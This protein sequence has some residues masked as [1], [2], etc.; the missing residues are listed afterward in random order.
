MG[1]RVSDVARIDA[2]DRLEAVLGKHLRDVDALGEGELLVGVADAVAPRQRE[3]LDQQ[4]ALGVRD[5]RLGNRDRRP[6]VEPAPPVRD[7]LPARGVVV[8]RVD[9][10]HRAAAPGR[11]QRPPRRD[12]RAPG[13]EAH[14]S[15][16]GHVDADVADERPPERERLL[17]V[18]AAA[19]IAVA[20]LEDRQV[21]AGERRRAE[22][23]EARAEA[24][25]AGRAD[26]D[27]ERAAADALREDLAPVCDVQRDGAG[28]AR[29]VRLCEREVVDARGGQRPAAGAACVEE[30]PQVAPRAGV[31]RAAGRGEQPV[32]PEIGVRAECGERAAGVRA[33]RARRRAASAYRLRA[34]GRRRSHAEDRCQRDPRC[35]PAESAG[36]QTPIR[37]SCSSIA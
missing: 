26:G 29:A 20:R 19:G 33:A 3:V 37:R 18:A 6:L 22:A 5:A 34:G 9:P 16:R 11:V 24:L 36:R 23:R 8:G 32:T 10:P 31:R 27:C 12:A 14:R 35:R 1:L 17:P 2:R 15:A 25:C 28:A 21:A 4:R 13:G 7:R 30:R